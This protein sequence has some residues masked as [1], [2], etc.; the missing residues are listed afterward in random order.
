LTK[1]N[2]GSARGH[3]GSEA[4]LDHVESAPHAGCVLV[5]GLDG[6]EVVCV[7]RVPLCARVSPR[8]SRVSRVCPGSPRCLFT[9]NSEYSLG[10]QGSHAG[11]AQCAKD[12]APARGDF[13]VSLCPCQF[14]WEKSRPTNDRDSTEIKVLN[15]VPCSCN[16]GLHPV[17]CVRAQGVAPVSSC[18]LDSL[19]N[20][21]NRRDAVSTLAE[22]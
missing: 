17:S 3:L 14:L 10:G 19:V 2:R 6:C 4:G 12:R 1:R 18:G 22:G 7:V 20:L 9:G 5:V 11:R 15:W 21:M 8:V 13:F 16:K